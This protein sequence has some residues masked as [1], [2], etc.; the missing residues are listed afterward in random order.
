MQLFYDQYKKD[1]PNYKTIQDS[2]Q[3]YL[4]TTRYI[5]LDIIDDLDDVLIDHK[6]KRCLEQLDTSDIALEIT[7]SY[8]INPETQ[9]ENFKLDKIQE[10]LHVLIL[11]FY[12]SG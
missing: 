5:K 7:Q 4:L 1:I 12:N 8:W 2:T 6:I 3:E 11:Y 10:Y 9:I